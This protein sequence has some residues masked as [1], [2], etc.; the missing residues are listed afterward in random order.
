MKAFVTGGTGFIGGHVVRQLRKRSY[1]VT[2]LA[3]IAGADGGTAAD[4]APAGPAMDQLR[5]GLYLH[6]FHIGLAG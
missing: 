5:Q 4:G 6:G 3:Q 2:A 1:A